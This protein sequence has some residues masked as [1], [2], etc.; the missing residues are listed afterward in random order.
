MAPLAR[1]NQAPVEPPVPWTG[2]DVGGQG[3]EDGGWWRSTR[4]PAGGADDPSRYREGVHP[5][6]P[7]RAQREATCLHALL[8]SGLF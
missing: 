7:S 3:V 5:P 4:Q 8:C 6:H 2:E 1:G